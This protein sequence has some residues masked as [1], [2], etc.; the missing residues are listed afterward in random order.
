MMNWNEVI[1]KEIKSSQ[2]YEK[3]DINPR[4]RTPVLTIVYIVTEKP[5][6]IKKEEKKDTEE[7]N[8]K[9]K[10][11]ATEEVEEKLRVKINESK[12]TPQMKYKHPKTT[13]Q[14]IGWI[15]SDVKLM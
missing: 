14:E 4:N 9:K 11:P 6:R 8:K 3:F 13:N 2:I 7:D 10:D 12:M 15:N 5:N 1:K